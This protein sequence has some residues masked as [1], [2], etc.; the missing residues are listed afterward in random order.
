[1]LVSTVGSS[2]ISMI[3]KPLYNLREKDDVFHIDDAFL[4][5]FEKLEK[6]FY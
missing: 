5:A 4:S 1:M 6:S 2:K 3:T